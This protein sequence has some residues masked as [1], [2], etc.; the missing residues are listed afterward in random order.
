M[1][2]MIISVCLQVPPPME[3]ISVYSSPKKAI[4]P[5]KELKKSPAKAYAGLRDVRPIRVSPPKPGKLY[6]C[7]S[8]IEMT[9]EYE[10]DE[11]EEPEEEQQEE[12]DRSRRY[13]PFFPKRIDSFVHHFQLVVQCW[14]METILVWMI[15]EWIVIEKVWI[16]T[17]VSQSTFSDELDWANSSTRQRGNFRRCRPAKKVFIWP[18]CAPSPSKC[19]IPYDNSAFTF[20]TDWYSNDG[21]I[22]RI[23]RTRTLMIS[24]ILVTCWTKR[25]S[26]RLIGT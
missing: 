24:A 19:T 5:C 9:T 3:A 20:F 18:P 4:S 22:Q 13:F 11:D 10:T 12:P 6:P 16:W 21:L 2:R 8:D 17:A 25:W 1:C 7:L 23:S 15:N 14:T 26:S